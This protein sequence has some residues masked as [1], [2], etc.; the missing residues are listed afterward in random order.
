[1]TL[2][3]TDFFGRFHPLIVHLPIGILLAALLLLVFSYRQKN[4]S[5]QSALRFLLIIGMLS[6]L[7]SVFT[8]LM[9]SW[10]G[11]YEQK[12][13]TPHMWMGFGVAA[14]SIL[15]VFIFEKWRT[16]LF[17]VSSALLFLAIVFTGHLGGSLT[18]GEDYLLSGLSEGTSDSVKQRAPIPN[19]QQAMA[20]KEVIR[21][22]LE[23]KCFGC[24]GAAK[25]KGKLRMDEFELMM[26]GGKNGKIIVP[27][28]PSESEMIKRIELPIDDDHHMSPKNKLQV[29]ENELALLKWWVSTGASSLKK[30]GELEQD[31]KTRAR[32]ASL[33]S[34][35]TE[36][37]KESEFPEEPVA[38]AD[39]SVI[40]QLRKYGAVVMPVSK[41]G[42]YLEINF[43]NDTVSLASQLPLLVKLKAQLL[44][45]K[46]ANKIVK[47]D[48]IS[49]LK[50]SKQLIHLNLANTN[51]TDA[52]LQHI[53]SL[54]NLRTLNLTGT[55]VTS[56]GLMKLQTLKKLKTI[57][58]YQTGVDRA[59]WKN[60]TQAFKDVRLDS[61]GYQVPV[62]PDD[63]V[64][65]KYT[66]PLKQ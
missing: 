5:S 23:D 14:L 46:L 38:T 65:V 49:E 59:S 3:I 8:G 39:S 24:H 63:T 50:S 32:L 58:L 22:I 51:I 10:E 45:L 34:V 42:N 4:N 57:Y 48:D 9:L 66:P 28:K 21:P 41:E 12:L 6:A 7:F 61:G 15:L 13:L 47:D 43:I 30:V 26:A 55:K 44:T 19:V 56:S 54:G 52:A 25:Q 27:G 17:K 11:G 62:F 53:A 20:F 60:L 16:A 18:H 31:D 29:T 33:E 36:P 40:S 37:A 35:Q 64:E 2:S 1:M